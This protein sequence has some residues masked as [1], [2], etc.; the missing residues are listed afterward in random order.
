LRRHRIE[1]VSAQA[2]TAVAE[3][4]RGKLHVLSLN[5]RRRLTR[6]ER[7]SVSSQIATARINPR[8]NYYVL[9]APRPNVVSALSIQRV[10]DKSRPCT[11]EYLLQDRHKT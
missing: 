9:A 7:S 11:Q 4:D 2:A 6:T 5:E 10:Q 8:N 3:S 1:G